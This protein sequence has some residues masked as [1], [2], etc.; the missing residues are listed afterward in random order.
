MSGGL[1]FPRVLLVLLVCAPATAAAQTR[2]EAPGG[3]AAQNITNSPINIG[4]TPEQ[5]K[6]LT[7]AAARGATGR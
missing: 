7:E 4:L 3:V 1:F 5:V 6:E 2:I